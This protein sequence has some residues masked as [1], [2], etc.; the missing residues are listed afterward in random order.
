MNTELFRTSAEDY[1]PIEIIS[2]LLRLSLGWS[3]DVVPHPD[4][5]RVAVRLL[6]EPENVVFL[7]DALESVDTPSDGIGQ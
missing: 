5:M 7:R 3:K 4:S 6:L 2:G 1:D